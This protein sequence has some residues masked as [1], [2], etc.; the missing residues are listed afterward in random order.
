MRKLYI[1]DNAFITKKTHSHHDALT[2]FESIAAL[3]LNPILVI[4]KDAEIPSE[5][6]K[7]SQKIVKYFNKILFR[8][9]NWNNV[10]FFANEYADELINYISS[11]DLLYF[12]NVSSD[13]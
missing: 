10:D 6:S 2:I 13:E 9:D 7:Y 3:K 1:Y 11:D 12:P 5:L 4:T 8:S